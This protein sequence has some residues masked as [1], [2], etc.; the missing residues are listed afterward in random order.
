MF[1][2]VM[3]Y[4]I[5]FWSIIF[6]LFKTFS[7]SIGYFAPEVIQKKEYGKSVDW[8]LLGVLFYELLTGIIPFYSTNNEEMFRIIQKDEVKIHKIISKEAAG[9]IKQLMEKNPDKRLGGAGRDALEIKEH[10]YFKDVNWNEIYE[11]KIK[12]PN[13]FDYTNF[14]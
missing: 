6:S 7:G 5:I 1:L 4:L 12:S 10:P 9:L 3:A 13:F 14:Q 2:S 8:Y 11:K